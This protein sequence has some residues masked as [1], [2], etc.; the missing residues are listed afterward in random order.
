MARP[1]KYESRAARQKA[2]LERKKA[3]TT[4]T[5]SADESGDQGLEPRPIQ[6]TSVFENENP[7]DPD[8]ATRRVM[9]AASTV[10]LTEEGYVQACLDQ[11][12]AYI[13]QSLKPG[14]EKVTKLAIQERLARA[15]A[16]AR[17]RW[18]GF[19]RGE[20]ASL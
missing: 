19:H 12:K 13:E 7:P 11:T 18:A 8:T 2:Y 17:W 9:A 14:T 5:G 3:G 10:G 1:K 4:S 16:Y 6:S 15:E 20:I